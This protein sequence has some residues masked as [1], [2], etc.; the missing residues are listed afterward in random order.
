MYGF[1]K[2]ATYQTPL[3]VNVEAFRGSSSLP[4]GHFQVGNRLVYKVGESFRE[5]ETGS[6]NIGRWFWVF[7]PEETDSWP[8]SWRPRHRQSH[9]HATWPHAVWHE[10]CS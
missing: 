5:K 7:L 9:E 4:D 3:D 6:R 1:G 10:L 8:C 2:A